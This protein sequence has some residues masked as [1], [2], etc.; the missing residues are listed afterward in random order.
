[1]YALDLKRCPH[2]AATLDSMAV[3]G[4]HAP[5][6]SSRVIVCRRCD[7]APRSD[8]AEFVPRG[9]SDPPR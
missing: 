4:T 8:Q 5:D 7:G 3:D 1:M 6:P 2:C 9:W